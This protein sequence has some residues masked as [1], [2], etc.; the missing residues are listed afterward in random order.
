[1]YFSAYMF[2]LFLDLIYIHNYIL[3]ELEVPKPMH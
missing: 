2:N 3:L 1:M